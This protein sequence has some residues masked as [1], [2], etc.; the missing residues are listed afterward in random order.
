MAA[1]SDHYVRTYRRR[2]CRCPLLRI[3][4][5][6]G[7][8]RFVFRNAGARVRGDFALLFL[9]YSPS[10]PPVAVVLFRFGA[11]AVKRGTQSPLIASWLASLLGRD[12]CTVHL[13]AAVSTRL[14]LLAA[15]FLSACPG[16]GSLA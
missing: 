16:L 10:P 14:A 1:F 12:T 5:A 7:V 9:F 11:S 3:E 6:T 8:E 15:A 13:V 4:T 2:A